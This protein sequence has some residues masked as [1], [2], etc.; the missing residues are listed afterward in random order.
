MNLNEK[1]ALIKQAVRK[2]ADKY[3]MFTEDDLAN[4]AWMHKQVRE[5]DKP[6]HVIRAARNACVDFLRRWYKMGT[7]RHIRVSSMSVLARGINKNTLDIPN[8]CDFDTETLKEELLSKMSNIERAIV[9]G[10]LSGMKY[11]EI[12]AK[13]GC[14]LNHIKYVNGRMISRMCKKK[15]ALLG[16]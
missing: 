12:A 4:E 6:T 13:T 8:E 10:K 16:E 9:E 5:A 11:R 3:G 2:Y 1:Y 7:K 14:T 15:D